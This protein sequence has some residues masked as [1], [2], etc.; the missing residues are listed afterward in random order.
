[1]GVCSVARCIYFTVTIKNNKELKRNKKVGLY[2]F[3]FNGCYLVEFVFK[4][5]AF[6]LKV[7]LYRVFLLFFHISFREQNI[8]YQL[9]N[10]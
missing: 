10:F 5:F 3:A 2:T 4:Q 7:Q 8:F 9:K 6:F 1:M